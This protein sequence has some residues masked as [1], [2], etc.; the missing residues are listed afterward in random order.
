MQARM[1]ANA[2]APRTLNTGFMGQRGTFAGINALTADKEALAKAQQMIAQG[3]E[4]AKVWYETGWGQGADGKWRF[5]I[6]DSKAQFTS[7][8]IKELRNK[9]GKTQGAIFPHQDLAAAYPESS[10][11]W[12]VKQGGDGASY[13]SGEMGKSDMISI[14]IPKRG[15]TDLSNLRRSNLHELQHAIQ[16]REGFARGG[17]MNDF[18]KSKDPFEEYR[19]V[20]GE[21]ESRTVERRADLSPQQRRDNYPF[22]SGD[23]GYDVIPEHQNIQFEQNISK[24]QRPL[25]EFEQAHLI[26]QRN[27]ALPV[28]QGGLGLAPD[29]TAMDRARAMGFDAEA[30]HGTNTVFDGFNASGWSST[31]PSYADNIASRK[32]M[33]QGGNEV[34]IPLLV[35]NENAMRVNSQR[36]PLSIV[37]EAKNSGYSGVVGD[38]FYVN[39]PKNIRSRFA[40]FDPMKKNL[41]DLLAQNAGFIPSAGLMAYLYGQQQDGN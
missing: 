11:I 29:N 41:S 31:S 19:R 24:S 5:E 13:R 38:G 40:A 2:N 36:A 1:I 33:L 6:D 20:A 17:N 8:A 9:N 15:A 27:A 16:E 34:N 7:D 30:Y 25:T 37:D 26:A 14:G 4:P 28:S 23:Y 22:D 32:A 35:N 12:T 39:S 18:P 21:V 3:V 10:D